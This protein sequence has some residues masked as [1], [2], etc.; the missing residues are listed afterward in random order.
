MSNGETIPSSFNDVQ[1][2]SYFQCHDG[3]SADD[4]IDQCIFVIHSSP[5]TCE[6]DNTLFYDTYEIEILDTRTS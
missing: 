3:N 2:H 1:H 4:V 5:S 6:F